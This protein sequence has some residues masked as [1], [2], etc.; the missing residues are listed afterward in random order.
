MLKRAYSILHVKSVDGDKRIITGMATTP[1][2]DRMG[3]VVEPLGVQFKNPLPLLLYH[4][5]Q[6][7]VGTVKF[8]R[9]A[10]RSKRGC[11]WSTNQG[12]SAIELRKP[13][14]VSR[15]AC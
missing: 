8:S 1:T 7:P 14:R 3:D 6:K 13:G 15:P 11:R 4:N 10:S 9:T 12:P 2:P 5:S